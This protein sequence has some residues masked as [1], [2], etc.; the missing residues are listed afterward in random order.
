MGAPNL[1]ATL[2]IG[3]SLLAGERPAQAVA[4]LHRAGRLF[5]VH[6]NDNDRSFDW[7]MLPGSFNLWEFI[8]FFFYLREAG[9]TDDWYAYDVA[10][11]E[12][13]TA[14]FFTAVTRMTRRMEAAT[15]K[16]DRGKTLALMR[17]RNPARSLLNLFDSVLP[18]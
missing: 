16:L 9:Y 2:D 1:G 10:S 17:E 5:Y 11:K 14:E 7:D 3:H 18:G 4:M 6:L 8:E 12:I 13:D 15:E